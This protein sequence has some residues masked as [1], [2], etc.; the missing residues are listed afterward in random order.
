MV[1]GR[2]RTTTPEPEELIKLGEDLVKWATEETDE[3]RLRFCEWYS[4]KHGI[5]DKE[6]ELMVRK[7]EFGGYYEK[8]RTALARNWLHKYENS[9][10]AHRFMR[11]YCPDVKREENETK[12]FEA[13]L[14]KEVAKVQN[15]K[16]EQAAESIKVM[17]SEAHSERKIDK[18]KAAKE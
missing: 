12:E 18:T 4:L 6:W 5:L 9:S 15:E 3:L 14:N 16:I 8:A 17:I 11:I 1:A 13:R 2:P 7:E 10:I